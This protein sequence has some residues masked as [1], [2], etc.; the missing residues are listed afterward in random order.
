MPVIRQRRVSQQAGSQPI[1]GLAHDFFEGVVVSRFVEERGTPHR[2]VE[3][4]VDTA[5]IRAA[6]SSG[7]E[8]W[9]SVP[10]RSVK[11]I[12]PNL[13]SGRPNRR[14]IGIGRW[15]KQRQE[16]GAAT[17]NSGKLVRRHLAREGKKSREKPAF[18]RIEPLCSYRCCYSVSLNPHLPIASAKKHVQRFR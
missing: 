8:G 16:L 4:V 13:F 2:S 7:H 1:P 15:P 11:K 17:I 14:R 3:D 12:E 10:H 9:V 18:S 5:G 6:E